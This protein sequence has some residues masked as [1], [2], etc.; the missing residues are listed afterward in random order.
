M[1]FKKVTVTPMPDTAPAKVDHLPREISSLIGEK[2]ARPAPSRRSVTLAADA[3]RAIPAAAQVGV[4][5]AP[6]GW[7]LRRFDWPAE[8]PRGR[9]LFQAGRGDSFEKYLETIA[10]LHLAGWSVTSLDWRGQ[11]GSGR[12]SPDP[13]VGHVTDFGVYDADLAAFWQQWRSEDGGKSPAAILGHSMGGLLVMRALAA[14]TIDP[15]AAILVA[16]MLGLRSPL[17]AEMSGRI[18]R[19]MARRL[20]M[21]A[22]WRQNERPGPVASRQRLLTHDIE[23]YR[24]ERWWHDASPGLQLGPPSWSWLSQAF[25]GCAALARDSRVEA[26][27]VPVLMLVADADRLVDP[28]AAA[29]VAAR[30]PH[31]DLVRFGPESAHEILR[32][33]DAVRDRALSVMDGFLDDVVPA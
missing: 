13:Y 14:G 17:G 7:M 30:L 22:A 28:R 8:R 19:Y 24:D 31:A 9:F 21:R 32:E 33:S 5:E 12:L 1:A 26:I 11:G 2:P 18:A 16:P 20:P 25:D 10:H 23:R 3:R 29:R 6:D 27:A 15:A 4:W